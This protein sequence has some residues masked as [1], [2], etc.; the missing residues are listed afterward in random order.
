MLK[1]WPG[2]YDAS[3]SL[4]DEDAKIFYREILPLR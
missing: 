2:E 4:D 3:I 1:V